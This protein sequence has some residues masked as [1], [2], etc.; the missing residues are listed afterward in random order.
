[1]FEQHLGESTGH[2]LHHGGDQEEQSPRGQGQKYV[3]YRRVKGQRGGE[4]N[5]IVY[6]HLEQRSEQRNKPLSYFTPAPLT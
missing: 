1:M 3:H 5:N 2:L 4:K 6:A